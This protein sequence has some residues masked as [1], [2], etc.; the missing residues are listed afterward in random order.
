MAIIDYSS[1]SQCF[2]KVSLTSF[3]VSLIYALILRSARNEY[4]HKP[5]SEEAKKNLDNDIS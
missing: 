2:L 1:S 3:L 4:E 5:L